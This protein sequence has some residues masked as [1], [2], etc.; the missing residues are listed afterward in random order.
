M[1]RRL[2]T[3]VPALPTLLNPVLLNYNV[4]EAKE[5]EK[6]GNDAKFF[7]KRHGARNLEPL[8]PGEDVWI[9]DAR[10]QGTVL[11][12][13]NTPRSYIVQVPQGTLRRNR[14]HLVPLQTNSGES[15]ADKP[16]VGENP[17]VTTSPEPAPP[18]V[19]SPSRE[20]PTTETVRTRCGREVRKPQRLDL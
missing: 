1:G 14:H 7:N 2:R 11:S 17:S 5:R 4:L 3:T 6:R 8:V 10:V 15:D 20:G 9:T 19:T 13:H 18:V 12:T 16:L